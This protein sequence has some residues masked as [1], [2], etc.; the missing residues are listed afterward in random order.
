MFPVLNIVADGAAG[1]GFDLEDE[2]VAVLID[3]AAIDL[4]AEEEV[5]VYDAVA[6]VVLVFLGHVA[7][8]EDLADCLGGV[9]QEVLW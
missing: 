9:G 5:V 8:L 7:G 3:V 6:V 1:S 2:G 4:G